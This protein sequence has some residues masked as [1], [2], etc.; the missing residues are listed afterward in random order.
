MKILLLSIIIISQ[1]FIWAQEKVNNKGWKLGVNV[2][3]EMGYRFLK[4]D[5]NDTMMNYIINQRN[6]QEIPAIMFSSGISIEYRISKLFSI[7]SGVHYS[8]RGEKS[9]DLGYGSDYN[10]F[11]TYI[12]KFIYSHRY[13]YIGIPIIGSIY[14][15][16][17]EKIQLYTSIGMGF[18]FLYLLTSRSTLK[19]HDEE[20][21]NNF[22]KDKPSD[23]SFNDYNIFNPS[24]LVSIGLDWKIG[25]KSTLRIEPNFKISML[26][27][28]NAPIEG[29]YYNYGLNIGYI[30]S[31]K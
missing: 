11:G 15:M 10:G 30:Y 24:G 28:V 9:K 18:D 12:E 19:I 13:H 31:L 20:E 7:K 22:Q 16:N 21:E 1:T 23:Y 25:N 14:V 26:P 2:S 29:N 8:I 6:D 4:T 3:P 17:R 27:L 5:S